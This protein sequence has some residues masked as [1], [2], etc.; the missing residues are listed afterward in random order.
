M[1]GSDRRMTEVTIFRRDEGMG[2]R[3]NNSVIWLTAGVCEH[4][5]G[6]K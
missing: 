1:T 2:G 3:E 6:R 4:K 5:Q